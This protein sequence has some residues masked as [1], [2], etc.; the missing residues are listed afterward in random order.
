Y[1][2]TALPMTLTG[3]SEQLPRWRRFSPTERIMRAAFYVAVL[4]AIVW[5][6]RT[7]EIFPEFLSDA[8]QQTVDLFAR[9]WPIDWS[10]YPKL[11][12]GALIETFHIATVGTLLAVVVA[13]AVA[14]L[15]R[16]TLRAL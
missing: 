1:D 10:W 14:L 2:A 13:S 16:A 8:P 5:S 3:P 15:S 4:L 7:I 6:L 12:H 9:M 11:V